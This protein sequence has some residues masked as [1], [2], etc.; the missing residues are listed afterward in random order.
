[1]NTTSELGLP[2]ASL[3]LWQVADTTDHRIHSHLDE[4]RRSYRKLVFKDG[5]LVVGILGGPSVNEEAGILHNFTRTRQSFS[6]TPDQLAAGPVPWGRI[7]CDNR[8]TCVGAH[9]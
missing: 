1:M 5:I 2:I 3:G 8:I 6:V 9:L 7:L 4:S